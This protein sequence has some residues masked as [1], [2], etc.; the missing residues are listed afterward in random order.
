MLSKKIKISIIKFLLPFFYKFF[1]I[2]KANTRVINFLIEKKIRENDYYSFEKNIENF[3]QNKKM[4]AVD[5]GSQGGFNSDNFFPN[6]YNKF[7]KP[8]LFDPIKDKNLQ[9][10]VTFINKG[11]WSSKKN[12]T[13]YILNKRPGSSSMYKPNPESIK[14]YGFKNKDISI[15]DVTS[16]ETIECDTIENSLNDCKIE[17]IDYL[18]IDTQG[19]ELEIL[20]GL[21]KFQ[22][23]LIKCEVQIYPMYKD[24]PKWTDLLSY[25]SEL[26]YV[27]SDWKQIGSSNTRTPVEMDM[28]FLPNFNNDDGKKLIL[29]NEKKFI[30]LML[31]SGQIELLK[32]ISELLNL[33]YQD[34]YMQLTDRY[35][36]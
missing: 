17:N 14:M 23:L 34:F 16:T 20:K 32:R 29:N 35:F 19:A 25:L 24:V 5:V 28:I 33:K 4:V 18:K 13:L 10:N 26:N 36:N 11:L 2:L 1:L 15:F 8:I 9:Q 27:V 22:P 31:I 21:G 7:F 30:S 3:L 6:K 12:K